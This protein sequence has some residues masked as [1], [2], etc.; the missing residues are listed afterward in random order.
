MLVIAGKTS[1]FNGYLQVKK[2]SLMKKHTLGLFLLVVINSCG[3]FTIDDKYL[4]YI[5]YQG[6]EILYFKSNSGD[7]DS[8]ILYKPERYLESS[9]DHLDFDKYECYDVG[10]KH[11]DP[12]LSDSSHADGYQSTGFAALVARANGQTY[13][14]INM[15]AKDAVFEPFFGI[16]IDTFLNLK[17]SILSVPCGKFSDV[18]IFV[19]NKTTIDYES[20]N[21]YITKVYWSKNY[22]L[23]RY[24]K[25]DSYW[26]LYRTSLR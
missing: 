14:Y 13:F 5:P 4:K 12:D 10:E 15:Q 3:K 22:G 16:A 26:E 7:V 20:N 11:S 21:N 9:G 2:E 1:E 24:D 23:L 25:K 17:T 18:L 19:P 6:N 8:I